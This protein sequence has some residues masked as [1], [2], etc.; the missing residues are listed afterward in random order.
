MIHKLE[1]QLCFVWGSCLFVY[2]FCILEQIGLQKRD[3]VTVVWTAVQIQIRRKMVIN[4]TCK[5]MRVT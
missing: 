4:K 1:I 2:L 5:F 3:Y